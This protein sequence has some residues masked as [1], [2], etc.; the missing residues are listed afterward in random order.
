MPE[1][2]ANGALAVGRGRRHRRAAARP[3]AYKMFSKIVPVQQGIAGK[4]P[5][6]A[7]LLAKNGLKITLLALRPEHY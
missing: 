6:F 4:M 3:V 1:S 5:R 2:A 7:V